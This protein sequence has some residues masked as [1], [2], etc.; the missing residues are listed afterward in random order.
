MP[1]ATTDA[2][3]VGIS[4]KVYVPALAQVAA[5]VVLII[6]GLDKEGGAL[7]AAALGTL[8]LGFGAKPGTVEVQS[9]PAPVDPPAVV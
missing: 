2:K 7:L 3:T 8:G 6:I 5:G 9:N 1:V 4:P